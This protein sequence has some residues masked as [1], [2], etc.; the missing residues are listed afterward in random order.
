MHGNIFDQIKKEIQL[1]Q[2]FFNSKDFLFTNLKLTTFLVAYSKSS[3]SVDALQFK[4]L[5]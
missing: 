1:K 5:R 4:V 3:S 2:Q